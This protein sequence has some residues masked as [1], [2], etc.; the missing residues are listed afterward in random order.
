MS[1]IRLSHLRGTGLTASQST[2][3][4]SATQLEKM[5]YELGV[6]HCP[7]VALSQLSPKVTQIHCFIPPFLRSC[8]WHFGVCRCLPD[9]LDWNPL[10]SWCWEICNSVGSLRF[11][12][13]DSVSLHVAKSE[14]SGQWFQS[15][16]ISGYKKAFCSAQAVDPSSCSA[17]LQHSD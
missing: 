16:N 6:S 9:T 3:T 14:P 17:Q 5:D 10:H 12:D 7:V 13:C 11:R 2:K 1:W 15:D 4:L 8:T